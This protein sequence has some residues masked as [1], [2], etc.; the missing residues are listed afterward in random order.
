ML[1]RRKTK[2]IA[3]FVSAAIFLSL[4]V[5]MAAVPQEIAAHVCPIQEG[6]IDRRIVFENDAGLSSVQ[7]RSNEQSSLNDKP[8]EDYSRCAS[9]HSERTEDRTREAV[10]HICDRDALMAGSTATRAARNRIAESGAAMA[11]VPHVGH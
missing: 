3:L 2:A 8:I 11:E 1:F 9:D 10:L 7:R 6:G 5:V 4:P